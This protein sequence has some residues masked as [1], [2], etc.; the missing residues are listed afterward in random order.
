MIAG[1]CLDASKIL[2][3]FH[4]RSFQND[5]SSHHPV[6]VCGNIVTDTRSKQRIFLVTLFKVTILS[7][8]IE[9]RSIK[10]NKLWKKDEHSYAILLSIEKTGEKKNC[11]NAYNKPFVMCN[12]RGTRHLIQRRT[13][14]W[15]WDAMKKNN[16]NN[17]ITKNVLNGCVEKILSYGKQ[18]TH[19]S[20]SYV[21]AVRI[22]NENAAY[23][24]CATKMIPLLAARK[25]LIACEANA[26]NE[27][28]ANIN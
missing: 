8:C 7:Y 2:S 15:E 10:K 11:N 22:P 6:T 9:K 13:A 3:V 20:R 27:R 5:V 26:M 18:S 19:L 12:P 14:R 28:K 16:N 17:K 1:N 4:F 24:N 25:G 21:C 23:A